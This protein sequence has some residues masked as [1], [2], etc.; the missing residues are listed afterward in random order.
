MINLSAFPAIQIATFV[1]LQVD[2]Y[3]TTASGGYS[4][5]VLRFSDLQFE[6]SIDDELYVPAGNL[7]SVS[8][9]QSELRSS[10]NTVSVAL[11][12]IPNSSIAEIVNS[13]IKGCPL[14]IFRVFLNPTTFATVGTPQIR[15][16][17]YVNNY[18]L[19]EDYNVEARTATNTIQ[20][21]C[22]SNIDI[23]TQKFSGRKTNPR[24]MKSFYPFDTSM[25]RVPALKESA[26]DFGKTL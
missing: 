16:K 22:A 23:L 18:A 1:R 13:K 26:F 6:F 11:S 10:S 21:E 8:N 19:V 3:R 4:S 12:G 2:E 17:G 7:M 14:T 20:L 25:D 24:S 9:T 5:Q 15:F